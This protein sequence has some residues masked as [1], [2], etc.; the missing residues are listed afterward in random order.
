MA[1]RER[2]EISA[3]IACARLGGPYAA[4]V[5]D[6]LRVRFGA[7][8]PPTIDVAI[9]LDTSERNIRRLYHALDRNRHERV[10]AL[11]A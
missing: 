2:S 10:R 1:G 8:R 9:A 6:Q 7:S 3:L 4:F 11:A 5:L